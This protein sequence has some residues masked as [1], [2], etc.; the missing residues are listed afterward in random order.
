[1]FVSIGEVRLFADILG[2]E[3]VVHGSRLVRRPTVDM[4]HGGPGM[5]SSTDRATGELLADV[6]SVVVYDHR[7][8][9]RSDAGDA[10][11]AHRVLAPHTP[12]ASSFSRG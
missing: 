2:P 10:A 9:G 12:F 4:L 3:F 8:N 11:D 7:G 1:M 6:A 5:D